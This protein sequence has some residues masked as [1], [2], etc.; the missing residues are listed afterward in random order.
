VL[1]SKLDAL[2]IANTVETTAPP[3]CAVGQQKSFINADFDLSAAARAN[4]D[5]PF[6][7]LQ[8][9][10]AIHGHAMRYTRSLRSCW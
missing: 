7:I 1:D 3:T 2:T 6:N 10:T 8:S 5:R 9:A 4:H